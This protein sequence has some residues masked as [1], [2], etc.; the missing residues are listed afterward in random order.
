M[1]GKLSQHCEKDYIFIFLYFTWRLSGSP[2][3]VSFLHRDI[4]SLQEVVFHRGSTTGIGYRTHQP[5]FS[6]WDMAEETSPTHCHTVRKQWWQP[7]ALPDFKSLPSLLNLYTFFTSI[8]T[9]SSIMPGSCH[10][11]SFLMI[12]FPLKF[13]RRLLNVILNSRNIAQQAW[14]SWENQFC[15]LQL[16][17]KK[18]SAE[19]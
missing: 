6:L 15:W 9:S 8:K 12:A 19:I 3:K 11:L 13:L 16:D 4:C 18:F 7:T 1:L 14:E 2:R 5:G 17:V 10:D